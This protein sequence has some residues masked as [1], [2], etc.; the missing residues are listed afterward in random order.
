[1]ATVSS[2]NKNKQIMANCH[3]CSRRTSD[4]QNY[5]CSC[6]LVEYKK[7]GGTRICDQF[8]YN[9]KRYNEYI[10]KK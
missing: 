5:L 8:I 1:M 2:N 3:Y 9:E 10:T 6:E 4:F 7:H